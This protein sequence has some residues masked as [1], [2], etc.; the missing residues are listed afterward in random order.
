MTTRPLSLAL[1]TGQHAFDVPGLYA[2]FRAMPGIDFYP[3]ALEDWAADFGEIRDSYDVLVFYN[4]HQTLDAP[5]GRTWGRDVRRAVE[6]LGET[7]Q[8]IVLLHHGIGAFQGWDAWDALC[9]MSDRRFEYFKGEQVRVHVA[10]PTHPITQGVTDW[11]I[12]DEVYTLPAV[13]GDA[14]VLLTTDHL[15]STPT[16]AWTRQHRTARVFCY[17]SGHDRRVYEDPGF[18]TVLER[19][20]RWAACRENGTQMTQTSADRR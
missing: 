5:G 14:T 20:I 8:G 7:P 13:G 9:G 11:E 19:G 6:R 4:Y 18:R 1:I 10:D 2:L 16:L 17:Q 12:V 15:R 3:Q